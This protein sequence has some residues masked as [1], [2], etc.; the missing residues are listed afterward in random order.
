MV[1]KYQTITTISNESIGIQPLL[2]SVSLAVPVFW[3]VLLFL[4]YI[5][6][7]SSIYFAILKTTGKKRFWHSLTS[8][9]FVCFLV[10]LLLASMNTLTITILPGYWV[11]FYLILSVV[12]FLVLSSYK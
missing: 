7:T 2:Q 4:I 5:L 12:S 9:S 8:M 6:G 10:G 11:I 1:E 3:P